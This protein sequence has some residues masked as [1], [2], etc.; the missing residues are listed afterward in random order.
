MTPDYK[1]I[2]WIGARVA[3]SGEGPTHEE[4]MEHFDGPWNRQKQDPDTW[5]RICAAFGEGR[6]FAPDPSGMMFA[7]RSDTEPVTMKR[8]LGPLPGGE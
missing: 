3:A 7:P 5:T 1:R 4:W 8:F 2:E 6:G